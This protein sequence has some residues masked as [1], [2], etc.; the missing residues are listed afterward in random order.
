MAS[1]LIF[2]VEIG[3]CIVRDPSRDSVSSQLVEFELGAVLRQL[4]VCLPS[5][6]F[7]EKQ[8]LHRSMALSDTVE[9]LAGVLLQCADVT[10]HY[11]APSAIIGSA[12]SAASRDFASNPAHV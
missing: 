11:H 4:L 9:N 12:E 7:D 2:D 6:G 10:D 8:P 3:R 5:G 1:A